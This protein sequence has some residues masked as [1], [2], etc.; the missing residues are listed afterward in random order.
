[1]KTI[2][3][4]LALYSKQVT[5]VPFPKYHYAHPLGIG[6]LL[7]LLLSCNYQLAAQI[8][9]FENI[10]IT[11]ATCNDD[12]GEIYIDA[13]PDEITFE[14]KDG[15]TDLNRN[16]LQAGI[17][18]ISGEDEDGCIESLV[19]EVPDISG[20]MFNFVTWQVPVSFPGEGPKKPCVYV[21]FNFTMNGEPVPPEDL[22][23]TWTVTVPF[24]FQYTYTSNAPVIPVYVAG[25]I[26]D[27]EVSL[28]SKLEIPCC[29]FDDKISITTP[30]PTIL[31]PKVFVHK[32]TFRNTDEFGVVPGIVE[33]LVYGDGSCGGTT[34]LR[35][36]ILDDNN[37]ELIPPEV[38]NLVNGNSLNI[39]PGFIRFSQNT[40]WAA[41]PN[42]SIITIYE[43]GHALNASLASASDPTDANG[44]FNYIVALNNASYFTGYTA[45]WNSAKQVSPY[46]GSAIAPTWSLIEASGGADAMHVRTPAGLYSHGFSYGQTA[47]SVVNNEFPLHV[48]DTEHNYCQIQMNDWSVTNKSAFALAPISGGFAPGQVGS[49]SLSNSLTQLRNC[50]KKAISKPIV[51][52]QL[53]NEIGNTPQNG[54]VQIWPN[55]ATTLN[56]FPNPFQQFLNVEYQSAIPGEGLIRILDGQG[57]LLESIKVN[58]TGNRQNLKIDFAQK[59]SGRLFFIL[60][61]S[62]DA[63]SQSKKVVMI[64]AD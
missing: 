1:M 50:G 62:P 2:T 41:V 4:D 53:K 5:S 40:N 61:Q 18:T 57:R 32:C 6:L 22:N 15:T 23:I 47:T 63:T 59:F 55:N 3:G 58:C 46:S 34:D 17:Y 45:Q 7:A 49:L 39:D 44:D 28:N 26:L 13:P 64:N 20:C 27:I 33:L 9:Y 30:C 10:Q 19:L 29:S 8:N 36:Y 51:Q 25:T 12:N 14:W 35:G 37:G 21:G 24:P 16:Q 56:V 31:P 43:G 38:P 48:T 54:A 42:G 52:Q 11:P 60:F